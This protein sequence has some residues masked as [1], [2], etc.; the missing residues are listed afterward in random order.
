MEVPYGMKIS[1]GEGGGASKK[2]HNVVSHV[3]SVVAP[4]FSLTSLIASYE[5]FGVS[6]KGERAL[7]VL[8]PSWLLH[9][10]LAWTQKTE[11]SGDDFIALIGVEP[12]SVLLMALSVRFET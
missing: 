7:S 4:Y 10:T 12:S 6:R 3:V 8:C 11:P 5:S 2:M 9:D 1:N